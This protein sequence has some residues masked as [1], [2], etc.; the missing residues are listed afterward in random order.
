MK[1]RSGKDHVSHYDR[2]FSS[3]IVTAIEKQ[4]YGALFAN[5]QGIMIGD[6]ESWIDGICLDHDCKKQAVKIVTNNSDA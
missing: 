2:I 6:G 1:I 4:T 3:K 5:G